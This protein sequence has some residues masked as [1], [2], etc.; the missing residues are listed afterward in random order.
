M[1]F[2]GGAEITL[3]Q[4]RGQN[5]DQAPSED[6][7]DHPAPIAVRVE[8]PLRIFRTLSNLFLFK[9]RLFRVSKYDEEEKPYNCKSCKRTFYTIKELA[10]HDVR[11]HDQ[12]LDCAICEK[13]RSSKKGWQCLYDDLTTPFFSHTIS[14][15]SIP[16]SPSL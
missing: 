16:S 11:A 5:R 6:G 4:D 12:Q 1:E 3:P 10:E 2:L 7:T 13:V 9:P 15:Y 8:L 14:S